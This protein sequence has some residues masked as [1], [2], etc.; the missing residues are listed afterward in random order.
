MDLVITAVESCYS[1]YLYECEIVLINGGSSFQGC[2]VS[3]FQGLVGLHYLLMIM[4]FVLRNEFWL[5]RYPSFQGCGLELVFSPRVQF[6]LLLYEQF[7]F[8]SVN[9]EVD[10]NKTDTDWLFLPG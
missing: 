3:S 6:S 5:M 9:A 7:T 4:Q 2:G 8:G 10:Q 1:G